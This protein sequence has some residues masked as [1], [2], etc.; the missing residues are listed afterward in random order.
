MA[1]LMLKEKGIY[2]FSAKPENKQI[3][4]IIRLKDD[5]KIDLNYATN[6]LFETYKNKILIATSSLTLEQ[7]T[8]KNLA[9]RSITASNSIDAATIKPSLTIDASKL[10]VKPDRE[11]DL[12]AYGQALNDALK[13]IGEMSPK[14]MPAI[15]LIALQTQDP[16][17]VKPLAL[18][19]VLLIQRAGVLIDTPVPQSAKNLHLE[20][21]NSLLFLGEL[22]YNMEKVLTDPIL[23]LASAERY[24]AEYIKLLEIIAKL[25]KYSTTANSTAL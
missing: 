7:A 16:L 6:Q 15:P 2:R 10:T 1:F 9:D 5:G 3:E 19:K 22:I 23:A 24:T 12:K 11:I 18:M 20:L 8:P 4:P 17:D 13:P 21:T 25:N 14:N